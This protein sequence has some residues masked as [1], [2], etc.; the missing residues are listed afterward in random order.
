MEILCPVL[1]VHR[2]LKKHLKN[3]KKSF[4][5]ALH[6][7]AVRA[8]REIATACTIHRSD[9]AHLYRRDADKAWPQS[10]HTHTQWRHGMMETNKLHQTWT[11]AAAADRLTTTDFNAA[12]AKPE[13]VVF[14]SC[15]L[16]WKAATVTNKARWRLKRPCWVQR[17]LWNVIKSSFQ[18]TASSMWAEISTVNA[19]KE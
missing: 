1:F 10:T 16:Y 18:W 2:N 19:S 12:A 17:L 4:F 15:F 11:S 14:L 13:D 6:L 8:E 9:P 3:L 7:K 5:L